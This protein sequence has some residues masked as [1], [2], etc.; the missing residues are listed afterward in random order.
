VFDAWMRANGRPDA[1]ALHA[2]LLARALVAPG[3]DGRAQVA[4]V[5]EDIEPFAQEALGKGFGDTA[6]RAT[7]THASDRGTLR[8]TLG[9]VHRQRVLRV[10]LRPDGLHGGQVI[11][12]GLDALC[13]SLLGLPVH[14]LARPDKASDPVW[15]VRKPVATKKA[16]AALDALFAWQDAAVRAPQV[17]LPKSGF[18]YMQ[19]F[20]D[21][22]AD[23]ALKL[24]RETWT[25]SGYDGGRAEATP[26]TRVALRGRDPFY[27]DDAQAQ[28]RFALA[29]IAIFTALEHATP[30][31]TEAFA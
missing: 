30:L 8:G 5:L 20:G 12:H 3:A 17:F 15:S 29:S 25:G 18:R 21:K 6:G 19:C 28:Q 11:R 16:A 2:R 13:A 24:A 27:D 26:A 9:G 10:V 7:F 23:A 22:G 1:H 14:E 31:D 4:E